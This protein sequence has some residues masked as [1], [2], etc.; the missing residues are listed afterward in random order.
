MTNV[1]NVLVITLSSSVI[2]GWFLIL[3]VNYNQFNHQ[4]TDFTFVHNNSCYWTT[5]ITCSKQTNHS[6]SGTDIM[7]FN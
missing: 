2:K 7:N 1:M 4:F 5:L 3:L 6:A